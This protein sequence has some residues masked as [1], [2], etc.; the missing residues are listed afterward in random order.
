MPTWFAVAA[1]LEVGVAGAAID[2][3]LLKAELPKV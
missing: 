2:A 3:V 1:G